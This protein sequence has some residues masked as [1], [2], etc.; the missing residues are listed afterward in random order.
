MRRD[1]ESK[2]T[3]AIGVLRANFVAAFF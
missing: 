1:G 3:L 2:L